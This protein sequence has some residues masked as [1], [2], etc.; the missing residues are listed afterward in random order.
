MLKII[1]VSEA[2]ML[3]FHSLA[4][5]SKSEDGIKA[6][7]IVDK[8]KC[9]Y[10]HLTRVLMKLSNAEFVTSIKGRNGRY[11]L[12]RSSDKI[13]LIEIIDLMEGGID[14]K[15]CDDELKKLCTFNICIFKE[16][17]SKF[18][19]ELITYLYSTTLA[20]ITKDFS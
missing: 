18:A 7:D 10:T 12:K 1:K 9:S 3:A 8:I 15:N 16:L 20:N 6:Q 2:T 11:V 13:K 4:I 19:Q 5:I 14:I 17:R